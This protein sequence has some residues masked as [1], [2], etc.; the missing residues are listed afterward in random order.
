ME[1]PGCGACSSSVIADVRYDEPCRFCGLSPGAR[2]EI[3][4]I[5]S[6]K[7]N[8]EVTERCEALIKRNAEL[9]DLQRGYA[10]RFDAVYAALQPR[11]EV[12]GG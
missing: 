6:K 12:P 8:Q 7:A 9:E 10:A 3:W 5:R 1:C 11:P 4:S 2:T